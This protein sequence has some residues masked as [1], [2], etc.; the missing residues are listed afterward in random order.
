MPFW[1]IY[2]EL[3]REMLAASA[4]IDTVHAWA[5]RYYQWIF[6]H[7]GV[8][9]WRFTEKVRCTTGAS[10]LPVCPCFLDRCIVVCVSCRPCFALASLTAVSLFVSLVVLVCARARQGGLHRMVYLM[11]NPLVLWFAVTIVLHFAVR[12]AVLCKVRG[13]LPWRLGATACSCTCTSCTPD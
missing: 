6:N 11:G 10:P 9:Y 5:S 13:R 8:L 4:R 2:P 7:K 12:A 1:Y 3:N